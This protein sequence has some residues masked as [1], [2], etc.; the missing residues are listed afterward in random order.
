MPLQTIKFYLTTRVECGWC[1]GWLKGNPFVRRRISTGIC[2]IC[3][4]NLLRTNITTPR[5]RPT[6]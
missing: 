4:I 6:K 5:K 3:T 2:H 1:G